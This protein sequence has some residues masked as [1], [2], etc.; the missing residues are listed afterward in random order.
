MQK[1]GLT[2]YESFRKAV[3]TETGVSF[4]TRL[5]FGRQLP[6]E[7]NFYVRLAYSGID[8]EDIKEGLGKFKAWAES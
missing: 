2:T 4:C 8:V 7:T 6:G 1:K 3:L 5:H